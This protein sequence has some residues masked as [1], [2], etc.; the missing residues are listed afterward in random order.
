MKASYLT[1]KLC[2]QPLRNLDGSYKFPSAYDREDYK[3]GFSKK[4]ICQGCLTPEDK[5][6][7]E[8]EIKKW[9]NNEEN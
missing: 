1:C 8:A 6:F 9:E 2:N 5:A 4:E 3:D 7:I